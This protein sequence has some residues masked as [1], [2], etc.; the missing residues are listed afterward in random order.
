M[1]GQWLSAYRHSVYSEVFFWRCS[2][3][4]LH[5]YYVA[6]FLLFS[7]LDK[8]CETVSYC[9]AMLC[10]HW[11]YSI[12][13]ALMSGKYCYMFVLNVIYV[14]AGLFCVIH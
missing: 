5:L 14:C 10:M 3:C 1:V 12:I 9:N 8:T 4:I 6:D 13:S 2:L 7:A 11:V